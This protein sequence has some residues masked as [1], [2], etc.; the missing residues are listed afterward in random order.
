MLSHPATQ[1]EASWVAQIDTLLRYHLKIDPTPLTD[2]E[3]AQAYNHL[4]AILKAKRD[5]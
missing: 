3:W 4:V 2:H 5:S 1:A